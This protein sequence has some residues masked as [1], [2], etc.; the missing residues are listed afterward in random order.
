MARIDD[1]TLRKI[2][3]TSDIVE[4]VSDYVRLKK[5]GSGY[6]GLCPFHNERTPSFSVSKS[7]N[8]CKCFSC[9]KGGSPVG[10]IMEVEQVDY[11]GAL[12]ILARKYGITIEERELTDEE[13]HEASERESM[14]AVNDFAMRWFERNI[15]Q[16][17]EGR[18]IGLAYFRQRGIDERMIERFHLG[19]SLDRRDALRTEA[20]RAGYTDEFLEKTGLIIRHEGGGISDRFRA[21][22]IYPIFTLSGKVVGF[23]GRTLRSDKTMAKY[24]NSPESTIYHKSTELYGLYQAKPSIVRKDKCILVEGY[25]DVISMHQAGIENVVASSGTSLTEG[26]IRLIHRFTENVTVIY[27]SDPA[28]IKASLRGIDLLLAEGLMV[29]VL[30]LPDGDDPDSFAQSHSSSE[31]ERYIEENEGDFVKFKT[32]ILMKDTDRDPIARSR[33]MT[34]IVRTIAVI[35]EMM[36]RTTYIAECSRR[37]GMSEELLTLQVRR[38]M[39]A[40]AERQATDDRARQARRNWEQQQASAADEAAAAAASQ[41][42]ADR[43]AAVAQP[44]NRLAPYEREILRYVLRYGPLYLADMTDDHGQ[45]YPMNVIEVV[46]SL[47]EQDMLQFSYPP[48]ADTY[49]AARSLMARAWPDYIARQRQRLEET[50]DEQLKAG[51]DEIRRTAMDMAEIERREQELQHS[52]ASLVDE[53][54]EE[55][56]RTFISR[57]LGVD[58]DDTVRKVTLSLVSERHK[59]SKI[60]SKFSRVETERDKLIELV[61]MA[62]YNL[63]EAIIEQRLASLREELRRCGSDPEACNRIL[64]DMGQLNESK[65]S[66]AAYLGERTITPRRH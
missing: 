51:R 39:T 50:R 61:P 65:K 9:G 59:L 18:D 3:A 26:Q 20:L 64:S 37:F 5:R 46:A 28:G 45:T 40:R 66:L 47:L 29:K 11:P 25:M 38:E 6:I 15:Q 2:N 31:V 63:K 22:V 62:I 10:F 16:T 58:P 33:A 52:V 17:Q 8:F 27:D 14:L 42:Q 7:R 13:R 56:S 43:G 23:G 21:R 35:P 57:E 41:P 32:D 30:L 60:H 55:A 54:L 48:Y 49:A 34:E 44:A 1:A 24:V 4:V 53:G 19:Y 12:R 36:L